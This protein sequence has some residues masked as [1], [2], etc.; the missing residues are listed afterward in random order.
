MLFPEEIYA[1]SPLGETELRGGATR[2]SAAEINVL[3]RIDGRLEV[4]Q[5]TRGMTAAESTAFQATLKDLRDRRLVQRVEVD[6]FTAQWNAD[7]KQLSRAAGKEEADA[8]LASLQ[9]AGFFV[10]IARQRAAPPQRQ[11]GEAI[12]VVVVE[13]DPQL[14]SF[15]ATLLSLSGF[16]VRQ[17]GTREEVVHE[18]RR[19]PRPDLI[20]LDV[21]LPDADGFDILMR[22][23]QHPVLKEV[24]VIMLTGKATREAVLKGI[25][26]GADGYITKPFEPH[27][28][29][30]AVRSVL[31]LPEQGSGDR[32][33]NP[34]TGKRG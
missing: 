21:V 18:I 2:L 29:L 10:E 22:V 3:V 9:R 30:R 33:A 7:V 27:A 25:A 1:L 32:W 11:P 20:L 19:P 31:G 13:D 15:T 16:A 6:P 4:A 17:A 14:A 24:P 26:A 5:L 28:L 12:H 34:D 23:R 8:S